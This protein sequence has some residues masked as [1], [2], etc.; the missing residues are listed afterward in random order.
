MDKALKQ[1]LASVNLSL[2]INKRIFRKKLEPKK[3]EG[4]EVIMQDLLLVD[5]V[6]KDLKNENKILITK[7]HQI[8][9]ELMKA[10]QRI[11]DL[12]IYLD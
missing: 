4:I 10:N 2:T 1:T 5:E 6:L 12:S 9:L 8:N 3:A 7:L 11:N